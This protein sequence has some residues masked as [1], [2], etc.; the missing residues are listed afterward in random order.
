MQE[1]LIAEDYVAERALA[2]PQWERE[3]PHAARGLV[4]LRCLGSGTCLEPILSGDRQVVYYE[5]GARPIDGDMIVVRWT[6]AEVTEYRERTGRLSV[7]LGAKLF[8]H[9]GGTD[10]IVSREGIYPLAKVELVGVIRCVVPVL[11]AAEIS[12]AQVAVHAGQIQANAASQMLSNYSATAVSTNN[13]V[14]QGAGSSTNANVITATITTSGFAMAIDV[15]CTVTL[16]GGGVP[17]SSFTSGI[18][19]VFM[20]G[21]SIGSAKWDGTNLAN[22]GGG[23]TPPAIQVT[24]SATN[25]PSPGA[26]TYALHAHVA[27]SGSAWSCTIACVNNF[28]KVREIKK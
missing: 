13:N 4:K 11:K 9:F 3:A 6:A 19:D 16:T 17:G 20:D 21:A 25:T 2:P 18:L 10:Y 27:G 24:L 1:N 28:I 8:K 5:A 7:A 23:S 14:T 26:H 22:Y 12:V 15:G